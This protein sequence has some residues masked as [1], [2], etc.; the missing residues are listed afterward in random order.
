[1]INPGSVGLPLNGDPRAQFALIESVP[2]R[3]T[4]GG[5]RAS[6]HRVAYDRR[7]ALEAYTRSGML[8]AGG[9]MTQLFYWELVTAQP[10]IVAFYRWVRGA[11]LDDDGDLPPLFEA[12]CAQ[13]HRDAYVRERDPLYTRQPG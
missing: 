6:H 13:T 2:E 4:P 3:V 5:W 7:P 8:E 1:V 11:G 9:V 10:E 12:Y